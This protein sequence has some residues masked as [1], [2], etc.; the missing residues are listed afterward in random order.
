MYLSSR[1]SYIVMVLSLAS[2]SIPARGQSDSLPAELNIP[3]NSGD[4]VQPVFE[5]WQK[6][7]DGSRKFW[8]GYFNRNLEQQFD[9]PVGSSNGFTAASGQAAWKAD[10]GQPTHFYTGR[11]RYIFAIDVPQ[12]LGVDQKLTWTIVA[13]GQ[14]CKAIAFLDPSWEVDDGVRMMNHGGAGLA[15]PPA[16]E[17]PKI[18]S[19]STDMT[20]QVGTPLKLTAS[21]TD[22]GVPKPR[23][24]RSAS[25]GG[26]Q[27]TWIL[28]RGPGAVHF[29]PARSARVYGK[30]VEGTTEATFSVPGDYWLRA[31]ADDGLLDTARDVK[32]TITK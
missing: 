24:G 16:N 19:G 21:A 27:I 23:A 6:Y 18:I 10:Q 20:G 32:V 29:N 8:F 22:D 28:Y 1:L 13:N 14:T 2:G 7:P 3:R 11:Q 26:V 25:N 4:S 15:P 17:Y 9:I 30:T 12:S 31:V 5:G